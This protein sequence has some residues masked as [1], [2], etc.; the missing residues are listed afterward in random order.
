MLMTNGRIDSIGITSSIIEKYFQENRILQIKKRG[1]LVNKELSIKDIQIKSNLTQEHGTIYQGEN[2]NLTFQVKTL[3]REETSIRCNFEI[4]TSTGTPVTCFGNEF[5]NFP[6]L[7]SMNKTQV[8]LDMGM[9]AFKK[10][11]YILNAYFQVGDGHKLENKY[12]ENYTEFTVEG[13]L[14]PSLDWNKFIDY[15]QHGYVSLNVRKA[16]SIE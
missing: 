15:P 10:G 1:I 6:I 13:P 8:T 2:W 9:C 7:I 12:E 4:Q 11:T 16:Y 14:R 5:E 3:Y